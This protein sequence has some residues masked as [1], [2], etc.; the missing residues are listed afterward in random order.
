MH[1]QNKIN[2]Q[3]IKNEMAELKKSN[4][5]LAEELASFRPNK[6][7]PWW[8]NRL[9]FCWKRTQQL[10]FIRNMGSKWKI[11]LT[12]RGLNETNHKE[13]NIIKVILLEQKEILDN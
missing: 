5:Q 4:A 1:N 8:E 6:E 11:T 3:E 10:C 12:I 7:K 2:S 13:K 9:C